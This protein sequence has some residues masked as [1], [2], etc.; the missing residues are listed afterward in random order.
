MLKAILTSHVE[1]KQQEEENLEQKFPNTTSGSNPLNRNQITEIPHFQF[2]NHR[3]GPAR[4]WIF[5]NIPPIFHLVK[6]IRA[7]KAIISDALINEICLD[8][9]LP[10]L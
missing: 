6:N 3:A 2:L 7:T 1:A 10:P 5:S 4:Y 8:N 9:K